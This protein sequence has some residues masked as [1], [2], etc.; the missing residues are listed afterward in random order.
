MRDIDVKIDNTAPAGTGRLSAAQFNSLQTELENAVMSSGIALDAAAGPDNNLNMLAE[1]MARYGSG[2]VFGQDGGLASNSYVLTSPK[3]FKLPKAYFTGMM[4]FWYPAHNSTGASQLGVNA[5][6]MKS[7]LD[8]AGIALVGGEVLTNRL[9]CAVYDEAL[10]T[11]AGAFKLAPWAN[12]LLFDAPGGGSLTDTSWQNLPI[13]PEITSSGNKFNPTTG[14]G[15]VVV[16]TAT[17]WLWRGWKSFV[18]SDHNS[19][20]RTFS[21]TALHTYHLRWHA[22]GTGSATPSGTYPNGRFVLKDIADSGYNPSA[23]A[24]TDA[25]FDS[26]YDDMLVCR[27]VCD[28]G[29]TPTVTSLVN[30]AVLKATIAGTARSISPFPSGSEVDH[31]Y[32]FTIALARTPKLFLSSMQAPSNSYDS[33]YN[34]TPTAVSR[35][36]IQVYSWSWHHDNSTTYGLQAPGF[37]FELRA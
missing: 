14:T 31:N 10:L 25:A 30:K 17:T 18:S 26:T 1:A 7:L 12:A 13:Y 4:V 6:G 15:Q 19:G 5:I 29:N 16:D 3:A 20:A 23:L 37:T 27:V 32:N 24:E 2:G 21:T 9:C 35:T 33:D 36:A 28:S 34:I 11:G 22:P 8:H